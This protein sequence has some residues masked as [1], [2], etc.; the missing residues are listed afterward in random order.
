MS[1]FQQFLHIVKY[2]TMV[3]TFVIRRCQYLPTREENWVHYAEEF[4]DLLLS[5]VVLVTRKNFL[6]GYRLKKYYVS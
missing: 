4:R 1:S 6:R 3:R 5:D 2:K